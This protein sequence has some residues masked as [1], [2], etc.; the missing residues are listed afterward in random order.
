VGLLEP[1]YDVDAPE[2]LSLLST[3]LTALS[4]AGHPILCPHTWEYLR[5]LQ[6]SATQ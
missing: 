6:E 4:L 3:H 5:H 1:W 2:T